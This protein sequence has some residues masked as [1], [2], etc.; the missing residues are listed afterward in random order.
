M[1]E[2]QEKEGKKRRRQ[3]LEKEQMVKID[4]NILNQSNNNYEQEYEYNSQL[5]LTLIILL[6]QIKFKKIK[7][8][9][10]VQKLNI[11]II[12]KKYDK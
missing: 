5:H 8:N 3:I 12:I 7:G 1:Q 4:M 6:I 11:Y 2:K 10:I 9:I